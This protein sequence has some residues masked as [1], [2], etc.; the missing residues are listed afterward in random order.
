MDADSWLW[1]V[2]FILLLFG[3]AYFACA[4]TAFSA[5]NKIRIKTRCDSGDKRAKKALDIINDFD[6]AIST[7]LCG[8]NLCHIALAALA[9]LF[10]TGIWGKGVVAYSTAV[11]TLVV[12]LLCETLPKNLAASKSCDIAIALA[13]SLKFIMTVSK[14]FVFVF[15]RIGRFAAGLFGKPDDPTVTE[16]ELHGIIDTIA[17]EG[18]I[19]DE[20]GALLQSAMDF[21]DRTAQD[22]FTARVDVEALDVTSTPDE[23]ISFIKETKHSRIPVFEDSIDDIIGILSIRKYIKAYMKSGNETQLKPL[24]DEP[25][26]VP[27]NMSI[28]DLLRK[29][30]AKKI[31]LSVVTDDYGGTLGIVTV[32]DILEELVGDIWDEDDEVTP[33]IRSLSENKWEALGSMLVI[34]AFDHIGFTDYDDDD[35]THTTLGGFALEEM[36][37]E[38]SEGSSFVYKNIRITVSEI[39]SRRIIKLI[40]ELLPADES[41][42]SE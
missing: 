23:I 18:A 13:P 25:F 19:E 1:P 24:L 6:D 28:D 10:A 14:P 7:L 4:E 29:M 34:D 16:E 17:D 40:L 35:F 11:T 42:V 30:S 20:K 9:T 12:F 8:N 2:L 3:S 32:E 37:D 22:V 15:S 33:E 36:Q 31:Q 41:E 39:E 21:D 38:V 26:F 5:A 27:R